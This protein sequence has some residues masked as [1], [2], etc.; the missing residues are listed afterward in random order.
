M[1]PEEIRYQITTYADR[2]RNSYGYDYYAGWFAAMEWMLRK[3]E[4]NAE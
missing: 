1:T 4:E 3:A 2:I